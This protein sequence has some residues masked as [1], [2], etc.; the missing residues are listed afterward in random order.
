MANNP[1]EFIKDNLGLDSAN[2]PN[3]ANVNNKITQN[4]E[5]INFNMPNV[6]SY[7]ELISEMQRDP[8]FEKLILAMT[9]DQIAGKSKL[10]KNKVIR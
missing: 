5:N 4:F 1:T 10:A 8:K 3:G 6:H 7:N 2:I 9:V